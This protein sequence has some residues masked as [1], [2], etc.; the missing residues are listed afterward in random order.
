[1]WWFTLVIPAI[2]EVEA[3]ESQVQGQTK[4]HSEFEDRMDYRA[5]LLFQIQKQKTKTTKKDS[6]FDQTLVR[7]PELFN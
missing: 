6:P 7:L 1:V 3:G 5:R 4:L 2:W